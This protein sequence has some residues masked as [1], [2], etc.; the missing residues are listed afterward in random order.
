VAGRLAVFSTTDFSF[1]GH[2][3]PLTCP[4]GRSR[5]SIALYYFSAGRP[6]EEISGDHST[7]FKARP[8]EKIV[9]DRKEQARTFGRRLTPPIV[10]DGIRAAKRRLAERG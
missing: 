1:H 7:L 8:G 10:H 3:D 2:P 6:E 9:V 4:E 5:R